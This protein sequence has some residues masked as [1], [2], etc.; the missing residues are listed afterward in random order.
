MKAGY[1]R[2]SHVLFTAVPLIPE[3]VQGTLW[4]PNTH[5]LKAEINEPE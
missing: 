3:T 1:L 4:A 5:L 2:S